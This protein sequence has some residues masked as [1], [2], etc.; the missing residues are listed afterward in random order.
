MYFSEWKVEGKHRS[1]TNAAEVW[2]FF[3]H[4]VELSLARDELPHNKQWSTQILIQLLSSRESARIYAVINTLFVTA[5]LC[6][7]D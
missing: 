7:P 6:S 2:R 3:S 1:P 5:P 4:M